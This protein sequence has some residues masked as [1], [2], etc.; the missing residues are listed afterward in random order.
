MDYL[1]R[2]EIQVKYYCTILQENANVTVSCWLV[3]QINYYRHSVMV[4]AEGK[5]L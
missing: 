5:S 3:K 2:K 4:H 1:P